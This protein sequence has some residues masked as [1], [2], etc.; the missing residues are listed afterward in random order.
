MEEKVKKKEAQTRRLEI[1]EIEK[2]LIGWSSWWNKMEL[3]AETEK[4]RK[5]VE[6]KKKKSFTHIKLPNQLLVGWK[7][8][9]DRVEADGK[10]DG[11]KPERNNSWS[12]NRSKQI[13]KDHFIKKYFSEPKEDKPWKEESRTKEDLADVKFKGRQVTPNRKLTFKTYSVEKKPKIT[14]QENIQTNEKMNRQSHAQSADFISNNV[15]NNKGEG[16]G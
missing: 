8:W 2:A 6:R 10:R 3:E 15:T 12:R 14:F 1:L 13:M 7:G 16:S 4:R 11:K 5:K 9:W